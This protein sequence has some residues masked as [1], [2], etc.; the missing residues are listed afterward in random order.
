LAQVQPLKDEIIR[1][2]AQLDT[3]RSMY[4]TRIHELNEQLKE[5]QRRA[6]EL[7][8]EAAKAYYQG[9]REGEQG[10]HPASGKN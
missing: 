9:L 8:R 10:S 2:Q 4:E 1:I 5:A 6:E 7:I 3:S